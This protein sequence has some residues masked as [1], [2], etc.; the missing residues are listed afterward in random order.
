MHK[1][2][3]VKECRLVIGIGQGILISRLGLSNT[4]RIPSSGKGGRKCD[5]ARDENVGTNLVTEQYTGYHNDNAFT[6][7]FATLAGGMRIHDTG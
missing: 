4:Y 1:R 3:G 7:E 2:G 5:R 6:S